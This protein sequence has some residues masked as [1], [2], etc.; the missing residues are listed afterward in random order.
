LGR[1]VVCIHQQQEGFFEFVRS[2]EAM[3]EKVMRQLHRA[4]Q[5]ALTDITVTW[6]GA[7]A[8][9]VQPAPFRLPPLFCGGRLV[10]YGI[11]DDS[12]AAAAA[13]E[14]GGGEVEVVIGAKTAVK[15]FEAVVKV[16]LSKASKGTLLNKLAA[17]TLLKCV[18]SLSSPP[19]RTHAHTAHIED[20]ELTG[21]FVCLFVYCW[22]LVV[23]GGWW[24]TTTT[25]TTTTGIWR[26]VG[27]MCTTG[28]VW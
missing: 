24:T 4:M 2:G 12:A 9:H 6:K 23:G 11:I 19:N 13:D 28:K 3:E 8:R 26:R 20:E 18:P 25:T 21:L 27:A 5:P 1:V 16:D 10:V 15:P 17:R 22:W 14:A 7:A